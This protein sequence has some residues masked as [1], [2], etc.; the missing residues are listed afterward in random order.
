MFEENTLTTEEEA[1]RFINKYG[2]VTL[3]PKR[4]FSF[5]NLYQATAVKDKDEKNLR[6]RG[7]GLTI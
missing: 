1:F 7:S 3:F 5:P 4:G 2:F 6:R